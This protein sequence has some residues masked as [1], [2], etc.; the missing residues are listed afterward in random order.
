MGQFN[1][2]H[3]PQHGGPQW[4]DYFSYVSDW[5]VYEEDYDGTGYEIT[6]SVVEIDTAS[7]PGIKHQTA[8]EDVGGVPT[9]GLTGVAARQSYLRSGTVL[10]KSY[11]GEGNLVTGD[12]ATH[13][14]FFNP[15]GG[16][17]ELDDPDAQA[18]VAY[19]AGV[20]IR[21]AGAVTAASL[22]NAS[23]D[24]DALSDG[25]TR[26][27]VS[28][29]PKVAGTATPSDAL[30]L[31][32]DSQVKGEFSSA[33]TTVYN[34][35]DIVT[36]K[37]DLHV[38]T[39]AI[40]AGQSDNPFAEAEWV[41]VTAPT[42]LHDL[43]TPRGGEVTLNTLIASLGYLPPAGGSKVDAILFAPAFITSKRHRHSPV[44]APVH[45]YQSIPQ[46]IQVY[47]NLD[48]RGSED[49]A[50]TVLQAVVLNGGVIKV[51]LAGLTQYPYQRPYDNFPM[52]PVWNGAANGQGTG[53]SFGQN[54]DYNE[55]TAF[56]NSHPPADWYIRGR[57]YDLNDIR[58]WPTAHLNNLPRVYENAFNNAK[59]DWGCCVI[60][61]GLV[62]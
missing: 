7:F 28:L 45:G 19:S 22:I 3:F 61:S 59:H 56:K 31:V 39:T 55:N 14:G 46:D 35:G 52:R 23:A 38:N 27:F 41:K 50:G 29:R 30:A 13:Y 12:S 11:D 62:G 48:R 16:V 60:T 53:Q 42:S 40:A 51:L 10:S 9:T 24:L 47:G 2:K 37:G 4:K 8:T 58:G 25:T 21:S 44:G 33:G 34:E 20:V 1:M 32:V 6:R 49:L 15:R 17:V 57:N 36:Y 5:F 43:V 54:A 18:G 26:H